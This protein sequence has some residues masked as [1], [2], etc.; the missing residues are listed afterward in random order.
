MHNFRVISYGK[1]FTGKHPVIFRYYYFTIIKIATPV[2]YVDEV[3]IFERLLL[4]V[5]NISTVSKFF[6]QFKT[7]W[8]CNNKVGIIPGIHPF[9]KTIGNTL[10][11]RLYMRRPGENYLRFFFIF[12]G[13]MIVNCD[14]ISETLQRMDSGTLQ[15]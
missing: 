2:F 6:I 4:V 15:A 13:K 3:S 5:D 10:R 14:N 7:F 1:F 11:Q 8:M 9:A 12:Y